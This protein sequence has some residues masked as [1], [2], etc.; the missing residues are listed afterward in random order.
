MFSALHVAMQI[1]H[2]NIQQW[3]PAKI[4]QKI[5]TIPHLS[6]ETRFD[7]IQNHFIKSNEIPPSDLVDHL[8][9]IPTAITYKYL[10]FLQKNKKEIKL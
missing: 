6:R 2:N 4:L 9:S 5:A 10:H 1:Q 3:T 7:N 8:N